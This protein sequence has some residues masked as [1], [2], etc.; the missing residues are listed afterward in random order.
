MLPKPAV[1]GREWGSENP[2]LERWPA[3]LVGGLETVLDSAGLFG[4]PLQFLTPSFECQANRSRGHPV[5]EVLGIHHRQASQSLR[6]KPV[7]PG[8]TLVETGQVGSRVWVDHVYGGPT[9]VGEGS[10]RIPGDVGGL[11]HHSQRLILSQTLAG[12]RINPLK[13]SPG[14]AKL[15]QRADELTPLISE[16]RPVFGLHG[17]VNPWN[18]N[19]A[20]PP[21][22]L[23]FVRATHGAAERPRPR[24]GCSPRL[25]LDQ[26][27]RPEGSPQYS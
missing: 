1:C 10:Y 6:R 5:I 11:Q 3:Q 25:V 9:L 19:R 2:L 24:D 7:A 15:E 21:F 12:Q 20:S 13:L 26:G 8:V 23:D 17:Q 27:Q 18:V 4:Q 22:S 14:G 16:D